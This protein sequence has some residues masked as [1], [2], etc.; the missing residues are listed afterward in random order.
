MCVHT[1]IH[2]CSVPHSHTRGKNNVPVLSVLQ[3]QGLSCSEL[4]L[5]F[6]TL[7]SITSIQLYRFRYIWTDTEAV[8]P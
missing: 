5:F 3:S 7:F 2:P 8:D 6:Q 4:H 1:G